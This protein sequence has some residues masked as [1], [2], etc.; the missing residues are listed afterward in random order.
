LLRNSAALVSARAGSL[1]VSVSVLPYLV[2]YLTPSVYGAWATIASTT[3]LLSFADLGMGR[4]LVNPLASALTHD[5]RC[6]VRR[7]VSTNIAILATSGSSFFLLLLSGVLFLPWRDFLSLTASDD[8]SLFTSIALV[9]GALFAM[10]LALSTGTYVRLAQHRSGRAAVITALGSIIAAAGTLTAISAESSLLMIT[11]FAAAGPMVGQAL[12]TIDLILS[13]P[14]FRPNLHLLER[15]L[16]LTFLGSGVLFSIQT[17]SGALAFTADTVVVGNALGPTAVTQYTINGRAPLALVSLIQAGIIP[18]WPII[19]R[20]HADGAGIGAFLAKAIVLFSLPALCGAVAF[21]FGANVVITYLGAGMVGLDR[22]LVIALCAW[23]VISTAGAILGHALVGVGRIGLQATIA[24]SMA[25]TN[26]LLSALL[27]R[28][29]GIS[30]VMWATVIS[31][32]LVV[33]PAS[34]RGLRRRQKA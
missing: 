26:V 28:R 18:L 30:G 31:Y 22:S 27:V 16:A 20:R 14:L 15:R 5:D 23:I 13:D 25:I 4:S 19:H 11:S 6:Q 32:T 21:Y 1:L 34:M 33:F 3:A 9:Q 12:V 29:L 2:R 7:L 17:L 10:T 24:A 8:G